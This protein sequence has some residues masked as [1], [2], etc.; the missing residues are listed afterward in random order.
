[1]NTATDQKAI[2]QPLFVYSLFPD[3]APKKRY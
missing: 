3:T 1:M 2:K